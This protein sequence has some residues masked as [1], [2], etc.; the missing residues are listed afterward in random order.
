MDGTIL[1]NGYPSLDELRQMGRF[2]SE[3][4]FRKGPVAVIECIQQIPCDPCEGACPFGAIHVGTPITNLP[5]LDE[6]RCTGCGAC[7]SHCSGLAIFVVNK[8]YKPGMATVSFPHEYLPLPEKGQIVDAVDRAGSF[9]CKAEVIRIS[10]GPANDHTPVITIAV[11]IE[12]ADD[13]RGM[14]RLGHEDA[15]AGEAERGIKAA[16]G[17]DVL[18]CRCEEISIG[19]IKKAISEGAT[20]LTGVKRRTRAGMGLCQG[21]T[22]HQLIERMLQNASNV[23]VEPDTVRPPMV[24]VSMDVLGRSADD[25]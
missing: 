12:A 24:P 25:E 15:Y 16:E 19:D 3:E 5:V 22:C 20:T 2:P 13:V 18:V 11:P 8:A 10:N 21:R 7:I 6:N 9:V 14:K 17:D 23:P 4:R 1:Q